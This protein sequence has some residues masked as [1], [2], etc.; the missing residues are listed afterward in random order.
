MRL[1]WSLGQ[2]STRPFCQTCD[3]RKR[4]EKKRWTEV[5]SSMAAFVVTDY[6]ARQDLIKVPKGKGKKKDGHPTHPSSIPHIHVQPHTSRSC[7]GQ[8]RCTGLGP[9]RPCPSRCW[10]RLG[11]GSVICGRYE[12]GEGGERLRTHTLPWQP[13]AVAPPTPTNKN[14]PIPHAPPLSTPRTNRCNVGI[15]SSRPRPVKEGEAA[16]V[17]ARVGR[18]HGPPPNTEAKAMSRSSTSSVKA[19]PRPTLWRRPGRAPAIFRGG[20]VP[21]CGGCVWVR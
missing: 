9:S 14:V 13:Q 7:P 10:P 3:Q 2:I 12:R 6:Q 18:P 15:L 17:V 5:S 19:R 20:A 8:C 4:M 21:R 11:C 16:L 1:P